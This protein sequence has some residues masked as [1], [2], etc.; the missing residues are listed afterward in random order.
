VR[1]ARRVVEQYL[2]SRWQFPVGANI[3]NRFMS[4]N[5]AVYYGCTSFVGSELSGFGIFA[6]YI[7]IKLRR[8]QLLPAPVVLFVP[9][10][11][12]TKGSGERSMNTTRKSAYLAR[13]IE[14]LPTITEQSGSKLGSLSIIKGNKNTE[15]LNSSW[16]SREIIALG[17]ITTQSLPS[18]TK[19]A[20]QTGSRR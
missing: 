17:Y 7:F 8:A 20:S 16:K 1:G 14:R 19:N 13:P 15:K 12:S 6:N 2:F 9:K 10:A 11:S 3:C 18:Q 5:L 4:V